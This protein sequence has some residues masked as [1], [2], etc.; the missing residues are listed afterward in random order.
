MRRSYDREARRARAT[1]RIE[2]ALVRVDR[3]RVR[4]GPTPRRRSRP[5]SRAA[6]SFLVAIALW[7]L[8]RS[9]GRNLASRRD[10]VQPILPTRLSLCHSR[11]D[12]QVVTVMWGPSVT[13]CGPRAAFA[14]RMPPSVRYHRT[15]L[16]HNPRLGTPPCAGLIGDTA[17][18][19]HPISH[20]RA[21]P[22]PVDHHRE[23]PYPLTPDSPPLSFGPT[24]LVGIFRHSA[25][26]HYDTHECAS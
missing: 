6:R 2:S 4:I 22:P 19:D 1:G 5:S 23:T 25:R 21:T 14:R 11:R 3:S 10:R 7:A 13:V 16:E 18:S 24:Y 15:R 26:V 8:L 17:F 12:R 9:I 20:L